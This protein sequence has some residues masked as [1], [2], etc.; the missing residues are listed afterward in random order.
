MQRF[1][2]KIKALIC[3]YN[4]LTFHKFYYPSDPIIAIYILIARSSDPAQF[5]STCDVCR[6]TALQEFARKRAPR[7]TQ[8]KWSSSMPTNLKISPRLLS[9]AAAA[10]VLLPVLN[11]DAQSRAP[12]SVVIPPIPP[13][14]A[15]AWIYRDSQPVAPFEDRQI[16][17]VTLNGVSVGYEQQGQGFYRNV[18]PG[19]YVIAAP[20]LGIDTDESATVDLAAGQDAYFKIGAVGW[21]GGGEN[22]VD[23]YNVRLIPPQNARTAIAQLAFLSGN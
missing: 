17:A 20:S 15:R 9:F 16:E 7:A 18:A 10:F 21:P 11:A 5:Q 2:K 8:W 12:S 22:I 6:S 4:F 3:N 1:S 14:Q 13:G 19:H 23:A